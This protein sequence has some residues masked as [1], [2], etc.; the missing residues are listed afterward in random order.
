MG[1]I[2]LDSSFHSYEA[3]PSGLSHDGRKQI[4]EINIQL[5]SNKSNSSDNSAIKQVN[6]IV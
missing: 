4:T 6:K 2:S 3:V 5:N 1:L